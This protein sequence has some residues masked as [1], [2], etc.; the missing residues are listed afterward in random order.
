MRHNVAHL[1][2]D[3]DIA[4]ATL[5]DRGRL[6]EIIR[7][8]ANLVVKEH[9]KFSGKP[10]LYGLFALAV[11]SLLFIAHVELDRDLLG[12]LGVVIAPDDQIVPARALE[13][14]LER[15]IFLTRCA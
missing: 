10:V 3:W 4:D 8:E 9:D 12:L 7:V 6:K 15:L 11:I 2:A 1:A 13:L 14:S 5:L